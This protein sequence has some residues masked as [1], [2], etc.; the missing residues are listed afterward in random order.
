M[1]ANINAPGQV[2]VAAA[3]DDIAWLEENASS[4]ACAG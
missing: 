3:G 4:S 1:V 2:V